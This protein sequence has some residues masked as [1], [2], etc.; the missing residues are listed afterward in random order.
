[1][2]AA[3]NKATTGLTQPAQAPPGVS[4]DDIAHTMKLRNMTREQ[5]LAAYQKMQGG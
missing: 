3:I 2:E 5:V 1:M 4:E